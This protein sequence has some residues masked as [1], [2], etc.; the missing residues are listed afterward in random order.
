MVAIGREFGAM[1]SVNVVDWW[2]QARTF[3]QDVQT[4][5][6]RVTWPGWKQT[7]LQTMVAL[8]FVFI[9]ALYLGF[10][11]LLLSRIIDYFLSLA[12]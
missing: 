2:H 12:T 8:V 6:K 5:A 11:D 10:V 7:A 3:L 1:M 9:I 4:E